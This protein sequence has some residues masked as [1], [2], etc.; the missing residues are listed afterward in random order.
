MHLIG[1][2]DIRPYRLMRIAF[3]VAVA[4]VGIPFALQAHHWWQW[5]YPLAMWIGAAVAIWVNVRAIRRSPHG[6][7]DR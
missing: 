6:W 7:R 3:A 4:L 5:V 2:P 1:N